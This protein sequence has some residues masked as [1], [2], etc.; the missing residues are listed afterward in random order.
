[1]LGKIDIG[2]FNFVF[3]NILRVLFF[4]EKLIKVVDYY[5]KKGMFVEIFEVMY[6]IL[7]IIRGIYGL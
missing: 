2:D 3:F 7:L 6:M 4:F 5:V 1:M